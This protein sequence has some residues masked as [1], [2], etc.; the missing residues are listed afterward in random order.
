MLSP[1]AI[2]F[3]VEKKCGQYIFEV[4]IIS[5]L[6][7]SE[8][9]FELYYKAPSQSKKLFFRTKAGVYLS[10]GC[11]QNKNKQVLMIFNEFY[12]GN[13]APEDIYGVFDPSINKMLIQPTNLPTGNSQQVEKLIGYPPPPLNEDDETAFCCFS[14][15]YQ[16]AAQSI[17]PHR[18]H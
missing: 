5:G 18:P 1:K 6:D 10:T 2:A 8:R 4:K 16:A 13:T 3:I 17:K 11:I 14:R 7:I 12:G 15:Q 9:R